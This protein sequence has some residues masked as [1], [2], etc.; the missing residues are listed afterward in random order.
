MNNIIAE[1]PRIDYVAAISI[2]IIGNEVCLDLNYEEDSEATV[3]LN[4]V[5]MGNGKII[6][7]QGTAEK[8]PFDN[9]R[10]QLMIN[11]GLKGINALVE[12]QKRIV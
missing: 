5:A 11:S 1:D 10:L 4:L 3:D 7:V 9:D 12:L 2:G 6:E 8:A